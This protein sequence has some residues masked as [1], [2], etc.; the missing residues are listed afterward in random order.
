MAPSQ[1]ENRAAATAVNNEQRQSPQEEMQEVALQPMVPQPMGRFSV[2]LSPLT[3]PRL[4]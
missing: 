1:T 3:R 2:S 4:C